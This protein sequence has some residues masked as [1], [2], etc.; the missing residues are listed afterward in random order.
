MLDLKAWN[1]FF[2]LNYTIEIL[3][4]VDFP[5]LYMLCYF[6]YM[7]LSLLIAGFKKKIKI[8]SLL[9]MATNNNRKSSTLK[10]LDSVHVQF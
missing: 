4:K 5:N 3:F 6:V 7:T 9:Y 10:W 2:L 8:I 1:I